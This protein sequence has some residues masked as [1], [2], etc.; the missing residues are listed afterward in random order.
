LFSLLN[1]LISA[2][3]D[4]GTSFIEGWI[5]RATCDRYELTGTVRDTTGR[6]VPY[7]VIEVTYLDDRLTT[8]SGGDGAFTVAANEAACDQRPPS[9]VTILVLAE[10][11]RPKRQSVPF[12][13]DSVEL[14][15]DPRDFRP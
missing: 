9:T 6:P 11:Y 8:R 2:N 7:A 14:T 10:D 12:D 13:R 1:L 5:E 15:L 3:F 4:A